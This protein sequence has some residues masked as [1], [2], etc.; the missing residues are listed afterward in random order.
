ML[1]C[2]PALF[3]SALLWQFPLPLPPRGRGWVL[4]NFGV[5]GFS[6]TVAFGI[7]CSQ[8]AHTTPTAPV[9]G[10]AGI[11]SFL[12][13]QNRTQGRTGPSFVSPLFLPALSLAKLPNFALT[14]NS[15][16]LGWGG[17]YRAGFRCAPSLPWFLPSWVPCG[18]VASL[19]AAVCI[20]QPC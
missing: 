5:F 14:C 9:W 4:L 3:F 12:G 17:S 8:T 13:S 11:V 2:G 7:C 1:A 19:P 10:F 20:L 6:L 15:P 18:S 16:P